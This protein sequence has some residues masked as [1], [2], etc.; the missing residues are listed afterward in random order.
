MIKIA[1]LAL[2]SFPLLFLLGCSTS[3]EASQTRSDESNANSLYVEASLYQH[4]GAYD[5]EYDLLQYIIKTY[6]DT[7]AAVASSLEIGKLTDKVFNGGIK[8]DSDKYPQSTYQ[9]LLRSLS[10]ALKD[11]D[12]HYL[13]YHLSHF[14]NFPDVDIDPEKIDTIRALLEANDPR[15]ISIIDNINLLLDNDVKPEFDEVLE[16]QVAVLYQ[17]H[18]QDVRGFRLI[19][20]N[21]NYYWQLR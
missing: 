4:T 17:M 9:D 19:K 5:R 15:I 16:P 3:Y 21:N 2:A 14:A 10:K 6:P 8:K 13:V 7:S 1:P 18:W 20:A 11:K 12:A